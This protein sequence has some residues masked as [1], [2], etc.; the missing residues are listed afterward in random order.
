M[1]NSIRA[2]ITATPPGIPSTGNF[3]AAQIAQDLLVK[4]TLIVEG[5]TVLNGTVETTGFIKTDLGLILEDP[6]LGLETITIQAPDPLTTSYSLVLP[7]TSGTSG[8]VL[9]TDGADPANLSWVPDSMG[10]AAGP[11]NSIQFNDPLGSFSGSETFKFDGTS[12]LSVGTGTNDTF[13]ISG[14][15]STTTIGTNL[16]M[17]AGNGNG[18]SKGGNVSISSGIGGSA[19]TGGNVNILGGTGGATSGSGGNVFVVGGLSNLGTGGD[20][21]ISTGIGTTPGGF[22]VNIGGSSTGGIQYVWPT[23]TPTAG[24][25]L[26]ATSVTGTN[27]V[28]ITMTWVTP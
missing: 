10:S 11:L 22:N 3:Q 28:V 24:Q 23:V 21:S 9:S 16:R 12:V 15:D 8:Y 19:G 13:D 27:P 2:P 4:G 17:T 18:T 6:G 14:I 26:E 5:T 25:R 1:S 20:V 7:T